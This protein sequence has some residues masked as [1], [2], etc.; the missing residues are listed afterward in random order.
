VSDESSLLP[1]SIYVNGNFIYIQFLW[2]TNYCNGYWWLQLVAVLRS[3]G[4]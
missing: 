3:A 2:L 4:R 1:I